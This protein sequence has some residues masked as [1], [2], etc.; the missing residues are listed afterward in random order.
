MALEK[1]VQAGMEEIKK[2]LGEH[3][4]RLN[5]AEMRISSLKDE[6][7]QAQT[8]IHN[9]DNPQQYIWQKLKDL[10]N[11]LRSN[12]LQI[13]G[14]PESYK[15]SSLMELCAFRIPTEYQL[16][17]KDPLE[18]ESYLQSLN[19]KVHKN[20]ALHSTTPPCPLDRT[21]PRKDPP[22]TS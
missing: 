18:A 10:E 2:E 3:S 22:K 21:S 17:L 15:S 14:L 20:P 8:S 6:V 11:S 19:V 4:S 9:H 13:I 16:S 1:A 12:N 5:E 7:Y